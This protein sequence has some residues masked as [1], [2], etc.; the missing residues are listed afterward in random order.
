MGCWA[1]HSQGKILK[2]ELNG[3]ARMEEGVEITNLVRNIWIKSNWECYCSYTYPT[4]GLE[5]P[6]IM[7]WGWVRKRRHMAIY[8]IG[9]LEK[10][11][12]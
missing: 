2:D 8:L 4:E 1:A 3:I 6:G 10:V 11:Q 7:K 5:M 12:Q 9:R